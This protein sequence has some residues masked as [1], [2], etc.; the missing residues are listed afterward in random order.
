MTDKASCQV[1]PNGATNIA[2]AQT[3]KRKS[4]FLI[5]VDGL[6]WQEVFGG[7]E[8]LLMNKPTGGVAVTNQ[9]ATAFWRP[10][11]EGRRI[12]LLPFFWPV[13]APH[14]PLTG[15]LVHPP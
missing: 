8:A 1:A 2:S 12:A 6:R 10:T 4:V 7:A 5:T 13:I 14:R 15:M 11:S 9:L 3:P